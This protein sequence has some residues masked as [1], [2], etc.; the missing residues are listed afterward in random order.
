M[1]V[2]VCLGPVSLLQA[3]SRALRPQD[4]R[5]CECASTRHPAAHPA[6]FRD[7]ELQARALAEIG[8]RLTMVRHP[9]HNLPSRHLPVASAQGGI[10]FVFPNWL[11]Q[12]GLG[13]SRR[14][15]I[16][17]RCAACRVANGLPLCLGDPCAQ[18]SA[19]PETW[20]L[21]CCPRCV[22]STTHCSYWRC[23]LLCLTRAMGLLA[24]KA[25]L[26]G[27]SVQT[28]VAVLPMLGFAAGARPAQCGRPC[29]SVMQFVHG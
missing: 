21:C 17:G 3:C 22:T 15:P 5:A 18:R 8:R 11:N 10:V 7:L 19:M 2:M 23:C 1:F 24:S 29:P 13:G 16:D 28:G 20:T 25:R 12:R 14:W 26:P 9:M 27:A 6:S 4:R